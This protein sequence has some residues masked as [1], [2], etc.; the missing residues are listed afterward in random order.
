MVSV[1]S[2]ECLFRG[3]LSHSLTVNPTDM[4]LSLLLHKKNKSLEALPFA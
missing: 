4:C 3:H 1:L 2:R